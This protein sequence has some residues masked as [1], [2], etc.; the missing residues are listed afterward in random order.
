MRRAK[1]NIA[2]GWILAAFVVVVFAVTVVK[3]ADGQAMQAFDHSL[4]PSLLES[5]Q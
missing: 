5:A 3:L 1:R 4:R 2:V